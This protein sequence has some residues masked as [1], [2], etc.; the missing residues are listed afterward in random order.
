MC[1]QVRPCIWIF[2]DSLG[3]KVRLIVP[4]P[5]LF[6]ADVPQLFLWLRA[7]AARCCPCSWFSSFVLRPLHDAQVSDLRP[8]QFVTIHFIA[9]FRNARTD[10]LICEGSSTSH[11][12]QRCEKLLKHFHPHH[13]CNTFSAA[14]ALEHPAETR[15]APWTC[16][17]S[18]SLPLEPNTFALTASLFS[19]C[20]Q[21][22]PQAAS[23]WLCT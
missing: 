5:Q 22:S 21:Q 12:E 20:S 11:S 9:T 6:Q 23:P 2:N 1:L 16:R 19:S 17:A 14:P 3:R 15:A 10:G 4:Q 8:G 13:W 7:W 18:F